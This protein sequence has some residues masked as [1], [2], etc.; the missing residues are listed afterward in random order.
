M[1]DSPDPDSQRHTERARKGSD[2]PGPDLDLA[3]V[4]SR[5]DE[6]AATV[7]FLSR[8]GENDLTTAWIT[9]DDDHVLDVADCR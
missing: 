6:D 8:E 1:S 5:V 4:E 3:G 2:R 7:T 9:V